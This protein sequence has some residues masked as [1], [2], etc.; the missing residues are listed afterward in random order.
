MSDNA[1]NKRFRQEMG[2]KTLDFFI[3]SMIELKE[4]RD[5]Y[6]ERYFVYK[7][8]YEGL[9]K[10]YEEDEMLLAEYLYQDD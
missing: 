10:R 8:R 4:E 7:E 2:K 6:K 1:S 5:Y 3:N 9:Q